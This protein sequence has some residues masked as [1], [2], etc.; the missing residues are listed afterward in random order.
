MTLRS[1]LKPVFG[2]PYRFVARNGSAY[3]MLAGAL[4]AL[5]LIGQRRIDRSDAVAGHAAPSGKRA[6]VVVDRRL[7]GYKAG[8]VRVVEQQV[9]QLK[10]LGFEVDA[11]LVFQ[12]HET[13]RERLDP[14]KLERMGF[15]LG[16]EAGL[17]V[18]FFNI[19]RCARHVR[20]NK[21]LG[22]RGV[23]DLLAAAEDMVVPVTGVPEYAVIICNYI[24]NL[25]VALKFAKGSPVVL[26]THDIQCRQNAYW[27]GRAA[28]SGEVSFE[29]EAMGRAD[30]IIA[31]N[32]E[33][34]REISARHPKK[35]HLVYPA[36][37][38]VQRPE[39]PRV[40]D[41]VFVGSRHRPNYDGILWF[42]DDVLPLV[43]K[44]YPSFSVAIY[45]SVCD[46]F[47]EEGR[48]DAL[49]QP[50][51]FA[52]GV[53]EDLCEAYSSAGM[54]IV[55]VHSGEGIS[56]KTIEAMAFGMPFVTTSIGVRGF[57]VAERIPVADTAEGFARVVVEIMEEGNLPSS[58][59]A[60]RI[61][62]KHFSPEAYRAAFVSLLSSVFLGGNP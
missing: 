56:I 43:R 50:F 59:M 18:D 4:G 33:E 44:A 27:Q 23:E 11:G 39:V 14:H 6:M 31:L 55:P 22:R 24:W 26:E 37:A 13:T 34:Y 5:S 3:P 1:F 61:H 36:L 7:V 29:I 53:V 16:F 12:A 51:V 19:L 49:S 9:R 17:D 57:P 42:L 25:P 30:A 41:A 35:T 46:V 8:N 15:S 47:S 10:S 54:A 2:K 48:A 62:E 58:I 38:A 32:S 20:P 21:T 28:T 40:Y 45:G 52:K 60:R